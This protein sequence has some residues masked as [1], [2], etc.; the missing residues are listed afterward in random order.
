MS[1][2]LI[3]AAS[4]ALVLAAPALAQEAPAAPAAAPAEDAAAEAAFEARAEAFE[5][6]ME[7]MGGE[8]E[9]AVAAAGGDQARLSSDLDVIVARYQP[10]ADAFAEELNAFIASRIGSMPPEA[11]AQMAMAGPVID[12]QVRGAPAQAKA[13]AMAA[14][15][16]PSAP[17]AAAQE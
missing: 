15:A 7:A 6:R 12:A 11:Q 10:D 4:A 1:L 5:A 16:A 14:A 2:R 8:M 17:A 9:A 13:Q 3:L